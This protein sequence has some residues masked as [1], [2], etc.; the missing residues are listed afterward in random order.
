MMVLVG[1]VSACRTGLVPES[2]RADAVGIYQSSAIDPGEWHHVATIHGWVDDLDV[3][4]EIV[5]FLEQRALRLTAGPRG[6]EEAPGRYRY[7]CRY[8]NDASGTL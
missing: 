6:E 1:M 7:I 5:E 8:V 3:C 2:Q 4:T